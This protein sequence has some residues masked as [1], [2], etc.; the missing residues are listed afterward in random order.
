M[1]GRNDVQISCAGWSPAWSLCVCV[2]VRSPI[3]EIRPLEMADE[4][5]VHGRCPLKRIPFR[6]ASAGRGLIAGAPPPPNVSSKVIGASLS[7]AYCGFGSREYIGHLWANL[8]GHFTLLIVFLLLLF[9]RM[10]SRKA[11]WNCR[12]VRIAE[13]EAR[14]TIYKKMPG[15]VHNPYWYEAQS[16]CGWS[17]KL[18]RWPNRQRQSNDFRSV[19]AQLDFLLCAVSVVG[20]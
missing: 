3:T 2:C 19:R 20:K 11:I 10:I 18:S 1:C 17:L 6:Q 5:C 13:N 16:P 12:C 14:K 9:Y 7:N 15:N 8:C 4:Q